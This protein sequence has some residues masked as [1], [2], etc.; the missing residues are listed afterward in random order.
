MVYSLLG[1]PQL[2]TAFS[3]FVT[4]KKKVKMAQYPSVSYKYLPKPVFLPSFLSFYMEN[5]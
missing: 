4:A 5:E 1:Q 2:T 3:F